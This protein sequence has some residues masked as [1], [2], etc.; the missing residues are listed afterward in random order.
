MYAPQQVY[1]WDIETLNDLE[2]GFYGLDPRASLITEIAVATDES[3]NG[4]GEVFYGAE[5]A[6]LR[7]FSKF[8]ASLKPGL[9]TDWNGAFFDI[10]FTHYRS[11]RVGVGA[12]FRRIAQPG[13]VAKYDPLP[14]AATPENPGGGWAASFF[15]DGGPHA[16]LDVSQ[17]YRRVADATGT[18]CGLK[19]VCELHGIDMFELPEGFEDWN[20]YRQRLHE[21]ASA[22][23]REYAMSDAR[24]TRL[25]ALRLLGLDYTPYA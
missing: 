17:A 13:L 12:P 4:G 6:I 24:G 1:A 2:N 21:R 8:I 10:P 11:L 5:P 25:L 15:G 9:M 19:P 14:T 18:K 20:D 7:E 23:R 16:S 3:I 22:E